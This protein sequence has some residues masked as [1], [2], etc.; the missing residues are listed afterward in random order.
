MKTE[1]DGSTA[2]DSRTASDIE[3]TDPQQANKEQKAKTVAPLIR[4]GYLRKGDAAR[5]LNI[6]IRTLTDWMQRRI[7][8]F[9]KLSHRVCLFRQADLDASMNRFRTN[10]IGE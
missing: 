2:S 10:A 5:Y 3:R 1:E 7:V 6:S 8:P 9:I 4:P